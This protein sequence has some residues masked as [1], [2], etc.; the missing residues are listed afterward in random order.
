MMKDKSYLKKL[1]N[2]NIFWHLILLI[3]VIIS[4]MPIIWMISTAFKTPQEI[5][6]T[7]LNIIP[8]NPTL[9]NFIKLE[10]GFNI[11]QI[12]LNTFIVATLLTLSR[13]FTGLLAAYGFARFNFPFKKL[14]FFLCIVTLFVPI[15]VVMISNYLLISKL[16]LINNFL[17]VVLPQFAHAFALFL[18]YQHLMVFP[19]EIIEAAS[20]D[21]AGR[22]AILF[23]IVIPCIRPALIAVSIIMF[24]NSWN[25]YVW[26][27]I[28]LRKPEY[29]TL[30]IW[31]R[32]FMHAEAGL[33]W[34]LLMAA[35]LIGVFPVLF[36]YIFAHRKIIDTF[37]GSGVKG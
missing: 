1:L 21:G 12:I 13:T 35:S 7:E 23:K 19:E 32:H 6:G 34:G 15:Q 36:L 37:V 28:I 5:F 24:I 30:P 31:L 8:S 16:G 27:S 4:L 17:G 22:I 3:F 33:S 11:V 18:L 10:K 29:M 20:I 25:Q 9:N 2:K 14:L 26:P